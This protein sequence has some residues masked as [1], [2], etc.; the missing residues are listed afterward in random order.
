MPEW[1]NEELEAVIGEVARRSTVDPEFR[2]LALKDAP[3][4]SPWSAA[5]PLQ[6]I[7]PISSSSTRAPRK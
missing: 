5:A 6:R 2:A 3:R 4:R 1:T 7:S